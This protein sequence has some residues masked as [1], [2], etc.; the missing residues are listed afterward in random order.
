MKFI[1]TGAS[2]GIG[3]ALVKQLTAENHEVLAVARREKKLL[4]LAKNQL[5]TPCPVDLANT[6]EIEDLFKKHSGFIKDCDGLIN[7]A[8]LALGAES[9]EQYEK[10]DVD[11]MLDV[12]IKSLLHLS[13]L[14]IPHFIKR[15]KGHILNLGS[16]A[17]HV[18]YKGG[19]VYCATK[20]A[21]HM[22]TEALRMD[23]AGKNIRVSSVAPG[24][25][26]TE[27]SEVRFKGDKEK[28]SKVYQGFRPLS[29]DN[30]ASTCK[31]ILTQPEHVNIQHVVIMSTDQPNC[32]TIAPAN[33]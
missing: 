10:A 12:N 20:A 23:V 8:G 25:V 31:W 26:E 3:L 13:R 28:A 19:T 29:A 22:I 6:N 33:I 18:G 7:N 4:E 11:I 21:V 1:V 15:S 2:S 9:L 14:I 16:I 17:G 5:I 24:R 27:F 30:V 32:T